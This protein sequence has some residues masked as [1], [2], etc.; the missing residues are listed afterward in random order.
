MRKF[1]FCVSLLVKRYPG[2]KGRFVI[3][4]SWHRVW[5]HPDFL[6]TLLNTANTYLSYKTILS[7]IVSM[8][9]CVCFW[10]RISK[11][12][13]YKRWTIRCV[14]IKTLA[15][16]G[17]V[18]MFCI[19]QLVIMNPLNFSFHKS[20]CT[21]YGIKKRKWRKSLPITGFERATSLIRG[22]CLNHCG[23]DVNTCIYIYIYIGLR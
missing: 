5:S 6:H 3:W 19:K 8:F 7:I 20:V 23:T 22:Q 16:I 4:W 11:I 21:E 2:L 9:V 15:I 1:K 10:F 18:V 12:G 14:I 17:L 13:P